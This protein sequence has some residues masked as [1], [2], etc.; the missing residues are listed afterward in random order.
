MVFSL[1]VQEPLLTC[2]MTVLSKEE[3]SVQFTTEYNKKAIKKRILAGGPE[4]IQLVAAGSS[5]TL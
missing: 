4:A 1:C 3:G 5:T 2:T